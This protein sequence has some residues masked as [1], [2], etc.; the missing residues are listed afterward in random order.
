MRR[1]AAKTLWFA[2]R[3]PARVVLLAA[4][5]LALPHL[6]GQ[7]TA[8]RPATNDTPSAAT[9][10]T[11]AQTDPATSVPE[12][13]P[14]SPR[15]WL[16]SGTRFLN[17]GKFREA[18]AHLENALHTQ[19][20]NI[21]PRALYNIGHVR[22]RQG[23][24]ELKKGPSAT[25]ALAQGEAGT[26]MGSQAV[27]AANEALESLDVARMVQ[28]YVRGRGTRR[29]M[30]RAAEAVRQALQA[31]SSALLKWQRASGDFHSAAELD[32]ADADARHNADVVDRHI[33][34]LVDSIR[35]MQEMASNLGKESEE[36]RQKMRELK[37]RIP[38]QDMPPG[39]TG[40]E[41]EDEEEDGQKMPEQGQTE[42]PNRTGVE[43]ELTPEQAKWLLEGFRLDRERRL[44]MGQDQKSDP[45]DRNRPTW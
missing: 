33:A 41:E 5:C 8:I 2:R 7:T 37:G 19:S 16:N 25:T 1:S 12:R 26:A 20:A 14:E 18:E 38:E 32:P 21:Q 11:P 43:I 10:S 28:A 27:R 3:R 17:A 24:D 15:E 39:A 30:K 35:Q 13:V 29:G 6:P 23:V 22:F 44:P 34:K 31:Y 4:L 45:K 40:D 36:L 42:A 9:N